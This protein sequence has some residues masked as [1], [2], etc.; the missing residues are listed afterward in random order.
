MPDGVVSE[1]QP[2]AGK[3]IDLPLG[4]VTLYPAKFSCVIQVQVHISNNSLISF[5]VGSL[6]APPQRA[7]AASYFGSAEMLFKEI[8]YVPLF[9]LVYA[10][11]DV[12]S[13]HAK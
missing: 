6:H 7:R 10:D 2:A 8:L 13:P 5:S 1:I 12:G 9:L 11:L 4:P 3:T